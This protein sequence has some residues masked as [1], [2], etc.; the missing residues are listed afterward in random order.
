MSSAIAM[1]SDDLRR[2]AKDQ[3]DAIVFDYL[4]RETSYKELDQYA[5]QVAQGLLAAGMKPASRLGFLGKNT[6]LYFHI[7]C[8]SLI[9]I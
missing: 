8:L 4:G 5:S 3:P 2:Q 6:D 1:V 9:H 7:L